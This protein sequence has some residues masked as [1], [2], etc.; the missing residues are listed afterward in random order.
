VMATLRGTPDRPIGLLATDYDRTITD[1]DLRPVP[2]ALAQIE[3][4]RALGLPVVLATG[5]H[6]Q[7]L[8]AV[9]ILERFDHLILEG[10]GVVGTPDQLFAQ[11]GADRVARLA[12]WCREHGIEHIQGRASVSTS[13]EADRDIIPAAAGLDLQV[14]RNHDRLD[15]TATGVSK[16]SALRDLRR[17]I[18]GDVLF[19]GDSENDLD[20][21]AAS[22]YRV[23]VANAHPRLAAV[24]DEVTSLPGGA[25]LA[26]FLAARVIGDRHD[27]D[28]S[29]PVA[30][31][32]RS[33]ARGAARHHRDTGRRDDAASR[34]RHDVAAV[35]SSLEGGPGSARKAW[36]GQRWT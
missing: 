19:I 27:V 30:R 35:R 9:G 33:E 5:R 7:E 17:R 21:F 23:A 18:P 8:R 14:V 36:E 22:H 1:L 16:G 26:D 24:A 31:G 12:K 32:A 28:H 13:A 4:V 6:E 34:R 29:R 2:A 10:G 3:R 11:A 25:G 15:I 20:A